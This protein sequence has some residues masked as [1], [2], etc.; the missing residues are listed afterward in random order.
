MGPVYNRQL[1]VG[2]PA[3]AWAGVPYLEDKS[4]QD[5]WIW[6]EDE[7]LSLPMELAREEDG[8]DEE[9]DEENVDWGEEGDLDFDEE[10]DDLDEDWDEEEEGEEEDDEDW[11]EWEEEF[12]EDDDESF[13]KRRPSRPEWN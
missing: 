11:E 5:S 7:L 1:L 12:D 9:E 3:G 6:A 10:E 2:S 8:E 13:G 4:M